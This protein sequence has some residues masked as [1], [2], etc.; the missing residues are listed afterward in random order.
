MSNVINFTDAHIKKTMEEKCHLEIFRK[1][2]AS[3]SAKSPENQMDITHSFLVS[4]RE[5]PKFLKL[6]LHLIA[7]DKE[8]KIQTTKI[9]RTFTYEQKIEI[10]SIIEDLWPKDITVIN[11]L[12]HMLK[13]WHFCSNR[14]PGIPFFQIIPSS[15]V[16]KFLLAEQDA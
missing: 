4:H 8:F 3:L 9:L 2:F 14:V 15:I 16:M 5:N 6:T 13:L 1:F 10:L 12:K 7:A 11:R